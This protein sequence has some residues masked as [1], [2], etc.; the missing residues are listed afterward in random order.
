MA[1]PRAEFEE[2]NYDQAV[3]LIRRHGNSLATLVTA[4]LPG[5][6]FQLTGTLFIQEGEHLA[7]AVAGSE[8]VSFSVMPFPHFT[9]Q[10]PTEQRASPSNL[11]CLLQGGEPDQEV[12]L[13]MLRFG[14]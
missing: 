1:D 6:S 3:N 11:L 7:F 8:N 10:I 13:W 4:P 14:E 9:Y 12:M 5:M 2:I